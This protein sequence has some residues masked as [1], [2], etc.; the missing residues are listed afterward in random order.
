MD[1]IYMTAEQAVQNIKSGQRVF[2]HGSAATPSVLLKALFKRS[3]ELHKV[4]L[5]SITTLGNDTF[6]IADFGE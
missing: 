1:S 5:V 2:I 4:E 6:K 3:P